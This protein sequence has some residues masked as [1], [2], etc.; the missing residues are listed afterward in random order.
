VIRGAKSLTGN[1]QALFVVDGVPVDNTISK[2]LDPGTR[3]NMQA[4]GRGGYDYGNSASDINPDDIESINVLKGAAA[5]ALYG[6]RAANGVIMITTKKARKGL[7]ITV[8][9][10]VIVG[11]IDKSTFP[12]YQKQYGAGYS[13][14]YQKDGFLFFDVTGTGTKDYVV[15]TTED[16]SYGVKFDPNL[17]VY[18]WDAFDKSSPFYMKKKPWV[19]AQNDPSTF[20]QTSVSTVNNVMLAGSSDKGASS[21]AL[22]GMKIRAYCPTARSSRISSISDRATMSPISSPSAPWPITRR[23]TERAGMARGTA[24]VT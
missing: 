17:M 20:Y 13:S 22:H 18:Q 21:W 24:A 10:G 5:T 2:T 3:G 7:G 19:A 15:P 11:K 1:N 8:N 6:S 9:S 23:S 12:G 4:T 14:T 16:A